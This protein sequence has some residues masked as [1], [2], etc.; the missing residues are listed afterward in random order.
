MATILTITS[1]QPR[2]GKS[3]LALNLALERVRCG[4][5][6]GLFT[7]HSAATTLDHVVRLPPVVLH[8]RRAN[9]PPMDVLRRGYQ[10]V[11]IL[12]CRIPLSAWARTD[13]S[14]LQ[15]CFGLLDIRDGYDELLIDTS[16]MSGHEALA[17][18]LAAGLVIVL[19]TPDVT[20]QAQAFAM[21]RVLLLN[22]FHGR[23]RLVVNRVRGAA[24]ASEIQQAFHH[25]VH[26]HLGVKIPMLGFLPEDQSVP[27]A[28][29]AG[30]AFSTVFPDAEATGRIVV[31]AD[32]L[33]ELEQ[34]EVRPQEVSDYWSRVRELLVRPVRL[35]GGADL[36]AV[37]AAGAGPAA[38]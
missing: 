20:S 1:G 13:R 22:G 2:L 18:S 33:E 29:Q 14:R 25:Q 21:L 17:C 4:C 30:Q 27:L 32:A 19:V 23:L 7:E 24:A 8:E 12:G 36:D 10:G 6:T 11:D 16:G 31:L 3:Q 5:W 26:D 37:L 28:H 38:G 15:R 34:T 35:P 9:V